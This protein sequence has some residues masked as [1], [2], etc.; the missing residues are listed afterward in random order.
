M[1]PIKWNKITS[2]THK[3]LKWLKTKSKTQ[4]NWRWI[5]TASKTKPKKHKM[6][7]KP[8]KLN[9]KYKMIQNAFK[10]K[11]NIKWIKH[12]SKT[13]RCFKGQPFRIDRAAD[14]KNVQTW[15]PKSMKIYV[16]GSKLISRPPGVDFWDPLGR[17]KGQTSIFW[18]SWG[19]KKLEPFFCLGGT[20][21]QVQA[22][23]NF[24]W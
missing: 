15:H 18:P 5:K 1:A 24:F 3:N 8:I 13:P 20:P 10:T 23:S 22:H 7:E 12:A 6:I 14:S 11:M 2:T 9:R 4:K 19:R 16:S 21:P 17:N